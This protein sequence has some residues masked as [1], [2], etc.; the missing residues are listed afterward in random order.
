MM[1]KKKKQCYKFSSCIMD[2]LDIVFKRKY[3]VVQVKVHRKVFPS[4]KKLIY[5]S[6]A[7]AL[8]FNIYSFKRGCLLL[9]RK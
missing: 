5:Q 9:A 3:L 2:V 1:M 6:R 7:Q 4:Y 8:S